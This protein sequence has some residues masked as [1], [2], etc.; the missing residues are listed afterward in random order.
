M[1]LALGASGAVVKAATQTIPIVAIF[2]ETR[3]LRGWLRASTDP[4]AI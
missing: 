1:I 2:V 3:S 4:E